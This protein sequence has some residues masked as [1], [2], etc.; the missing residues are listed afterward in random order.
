MLKGKIMCKRKLFA[1]A[2]TIYEITPDFYI[3]N[4]VKTIFV[5]LD[6]TLDSYKLYHPK[7][8]ARKY[9]KMLHENNINIIIISNNRGK[10]VSTYANDLGIPYMANSGKPF[11]NRINK[12][13][14]AQNLNKDEIIFIGDQ[15]VTDIGAANRV[16]IKAIL[17]DKI[18]NEDQWTTH[19]NRILGRI[20]RKKAIKKGQMID[21]RER[22]GKY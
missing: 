4:N 20:L 7:D 10:R 14:R 12:F 22:Y 8:Q 15:M 9:V 16:G 1:H 18:V 13:I 5:D 21:W 11:G 19:F 17:T 6:N 2:K 3:S